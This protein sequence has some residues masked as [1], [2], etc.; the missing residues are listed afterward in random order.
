MNYT[1]LRLV[2]SL[3]C[4]T[5]GLGC[6]YICFFRTQWFTKDGLLYKKHFGNDTRSIFALVAIFFVLGGLA[7]LFSK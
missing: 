6:L 2:A 1:F 7:F 5:A 4:I 3:I